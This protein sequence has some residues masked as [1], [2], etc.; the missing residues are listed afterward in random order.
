MAWFNSI[1]LFMFLS[2]VGPIT[3]KYEDN[4]AEFISA[5]QGLRVAGGGDC[6]EMAFGGMLGAYESQPKLGSPM[7]VFT[8]AGAKDDSFEKKEELKQF[9]DQYGSTINFFTNYRG[10]GDAKGN[11]TFNLDRMQ[12]KEAKT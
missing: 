10:C 3:H 8:D 9:A 12:C 11:N 1:V 2:A 7:F 4:K 5:I 6:P